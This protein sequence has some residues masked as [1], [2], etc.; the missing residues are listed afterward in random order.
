[1]LDLAALGVDV[2]PEA[3]GRPG[4][5]PRVMASIARCHVDNEFWPALQRKRFRKLD[6]GPDQDGWPSGS[7]CD[8]RPSQSR[9][10]PLS[11]CWVH[12][13][14]DNGH[15]RSSVVERSTALHEGCRTT[16][17]RTGRDGPIA[18]QRLPTLGSR[19]G[20]SGLFACDFKTRWGQ[21]VPRGGIEPPTP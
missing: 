15:H 20:W 6:G 16:A 13:A 10:S 3:T 18:E 11:G 21:V 12:S 17:A 1:M 4:Y 7:L 9:R 19:L 14:S 8:P 5:D 2:E